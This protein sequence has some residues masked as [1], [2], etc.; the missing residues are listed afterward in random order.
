M[1]DL[2]QSGQYPI[3]DEQAQR[4]D[5]ALRMIWAGI[6]VCVIFAI[7]TVCVAFTDPSGIL[8]MV[9]L[10]VLPGAALCGWGAYWHHKVAQFSYEV[11]GITIVFAG[12]DYYV[13]QEKMEHLIRSLYQAWAEK[14]KD[15]AAIY[16][17]ITLEVIPDQPIFPVDGREVIGLTWHQHRTSQI[18]GPYVLSP[19]GAGY[20]LLLHGAEYLWPRED[21]GTQIEHMHKHGIFE[22]LRE[23]FQEQE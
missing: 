20:E 5:F 18:W 8:P 6:L 14:I 13:P 22:R 3:P 9:L 7:A 19:G 2:I 17:G 21:E 1:S 15:P 23:A 4:R 10:T 16:Q 12:P 11:E